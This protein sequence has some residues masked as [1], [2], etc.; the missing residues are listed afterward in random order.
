MPRRHEIRLAA[1]ALAMLLAGCGLGKRATGVKLASL[2]AEAEQARN[3]FETKVHSFTV[4]TCG[5]CHGA[6]TA[7]LFA[8]QDQSSAYEATK[9]VVSLTDIDS[10]TL[11]K[12][13]GDGHSGPA[14]KEAAQALAPRLREWADAEAKAREAKVTASPTPEPKRP[15]RETDSIALPAGISATDWTPME[16]HLDQIDPSLAGAKLTIEVQIWKDDAKFL[17]FRKPTV[18]AAGTAIH[19]R[20]A[21]VV[22]DEAF[23]DKY[24]FLDD[25]KAPSGGQATLDPSYEL[26]VPA[27][28]G[29]RKIAIRFG[30]IE[31]AP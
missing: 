10:S 8:V 3:V 17:R 15:D 18:T 14:T 21:A 6:G 29:A 7:P 25:V 24:T 13:A 20:D 26:L 30:A 19:A 11:L 28:S 27:G 23:R 31:R 5:G 2:S 4:Q 16:W 12:K 22:I 1:L 9:T